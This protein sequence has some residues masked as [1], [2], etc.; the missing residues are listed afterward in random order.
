MGISI[1]PI[2]FNFH[3]FKRDLQA[4]HA[5]IFPLQSQHFFLFHDQWQICG[6]GTGSGRLA[7]HFGALRG[8]CL[9]AYTC[10]PL[11]GKLGNCSLPGGLFPAG[12]L[13]TWAHFSPHFA[14]ICPVV[15]GQFRQSSVER[16][17]E[18]AELAEWP[19]PGQPAAAC[20]DFRAHAIADVAPTQRVQADLAIW[21]AQTLA[22]TARQAS[23]CNSSDVRRWKRRCRS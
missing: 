2:P 17:P 20:T 23:C 21:E 6:P 7:R 4:T 3:G 13:G 9:R 15:V 1:S 16:G 5:V 19:T 8:G 22:R 11:D 18:F 14:V 12:W 10:W